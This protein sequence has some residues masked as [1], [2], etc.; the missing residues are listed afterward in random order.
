MGGLS[1][2][3]A[4]AASRNSFAAPWKKKPAVQRPEVRSHRWNTHIGHRHWATAHNYRVRVAGRTA[5][6][7]DNEDNE[8]CC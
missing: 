8:A 6:V 2:Y 1:S 3:L 7:V 4:M 5:V